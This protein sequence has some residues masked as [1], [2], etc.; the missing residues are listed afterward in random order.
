[1]DTNSSC[2]S[3]FKDIKERFQELLRRRVHDKLTELLKRSN[4]DSFQSGFFVWVESFVFYIFLSTGQNKQSNNVLKN[5]V[6]RV[7]S[8]LNLVKK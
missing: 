2:K 5:S 1:M 4:T 8:H 6:G 3:V 7:Q